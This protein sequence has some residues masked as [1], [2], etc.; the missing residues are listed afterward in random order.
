MIMETGCPIDLKMAE[1]WPISTLAAPEGGPVARFPRLRLRNPLKTTDRPHPLVGSEAA[2]RAALDNAPVVLLVTDAGGDIVYGNKASQ[3]MM[4]RRIEQPGQEA[5]TMLRNHL[6]HVCLTSP[7]FPVAD[8]FRLGDDGADRTFATLTV[9]TIPDG[10]I[11]AWRNTTAEVTAAEVT[12]ELA[13]ELATWSQMLTALGDQL[14]HAADETAEQAA[15]VAHGSGEMIDSIQAVSSRVESAADST[16]AA[17]ES[18]QAATVNMTRL[19][20]SSNGIGSITKLITAIAQQTRLLALNATIEAARA[21]ESGK[22]FA[23]VAN[24]VKELAAR[25]AEATER[26]SPIVSAIQTE[27][28]EAAEGISAIIQ[29]IEMISNEQQLIAG[30]VEEQT[31]TTTEMSSGIGQ[32]AHSVQMTSE[33]AAGLQLHATEIHTKAERLRDLVRT[34]EH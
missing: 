34:E 28:T 17:V 22:G 14:T 10:Y 9:N 1:S 7:S 20:E 31:A 23:V 26:I 21:G 15:A 16:A 4:E 8:T 30:A 6:K 29:L 13:E 12:S 32:V 24:E 33:S 2:L 18:A 19:Q 27:S 11:A 25:T 5:P 3:A